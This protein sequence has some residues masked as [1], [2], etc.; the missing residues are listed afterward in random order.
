MNVPKIKGSHNA[1]KSGMV[2]AETIF[3]ALSNGEE[4]TELSGFDGALKSSWVGKDLKRVRN[5]KPLWSKYGF[6]MGLGMAGIDMWMNNLGI[7]LP[8]TVGHGKPDHATL[9]KAA[10]CKPINYPKPDN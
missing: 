7:G 1:M 3:S 2:A 9:K 8:F 6:F 5:V 4:R 10:D